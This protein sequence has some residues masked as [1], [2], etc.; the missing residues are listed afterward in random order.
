MVLVF[1]WMY[2]LMVLFWGLISPVQNLEFE[3]LDVELNS[4]TPQGKDPYF[5]IPPDCGLLWLGFGEAFTNHSLFYMSQ[6]CP[7]SLCREALLIQF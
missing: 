2:S 4:F 1:S 6:C 7:F 3:V 5:V